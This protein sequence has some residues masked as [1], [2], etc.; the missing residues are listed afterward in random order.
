MKTIQTIDEEIALMDNRYIRNFFNV[1]DK[2]YYPT[3]SDFETRKEKVQRGFGFIPSFFDKWF[4]KY[5][6]VEVNVGLE[7][8]M[9]LAYESLISDP[10]NIT[11][12]V[13]EDFC[14]FVRICEKVI[15]YKNEVGN[16]FVVDSSIEDEKKRI[17]ICK[18]GFNIKI[19]TSHPPIS[20]QT[21]KE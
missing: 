8:A 15:F 4:P 2:A 17:I 11:I 12:K 3:S 20:T 16:E 7:E 18:N 14:D 21:R 9:N 19:E 6:N 5:C 10:T 13:I 1:Y